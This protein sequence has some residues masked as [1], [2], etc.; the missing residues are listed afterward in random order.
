MSGDWS[1][2]VTSLHLYRAQVRGGEL[3][4]CCPNPRHEDSTPSWSV[5]LQ[6]GLHSCFGCDLRGHIVDLI[7]MLTKV[8]R[9][10]ATLTWLSTRGQSI[11]IAEVDRPLVEADV[12]DLTAVLSVEAI[13][14]VGSREIVAAYQVG[15]DPATNRAAFICRDRVSTPVGVWVAGDK[16]KYRLLGPLTAKGRGVLFGAHL[17]PTRET[18]VTEGFYQAMA[19]N[20]NLGL[21]AVATMGVRVT[22]SQ[23]DALCQLDPLIIMFDGDRPGRIGRDELVGQLVTRANVAVCGGFCGDPDML[24]PTDLRGIYQTRKS[25]ESYVNKTKSLLGGELCRTGIR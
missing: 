17:P 12:A 2:L 15:T 18:V 10:T 5:N 1:R 9:G 20:R 13:K 21:K 25:G 8:D 16:P 24:D 7:A 22:S 14:R 6:T 4:A 11:E 19:V 23:V 3:W